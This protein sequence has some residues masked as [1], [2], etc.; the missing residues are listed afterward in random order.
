MD[1][2]PVLKTEQTELSSTTPSNDSKTVENDNTWHLVGTFKTTTVDIKHYY[3][4][5]S[6]VNI[7]NQVCWFALIFE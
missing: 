1:S 3:V 7:D 2:Q 4:V 6:K 5:P